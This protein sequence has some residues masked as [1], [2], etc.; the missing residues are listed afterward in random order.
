MDESFKISYCLELTFYL[1]IL[2]QTI[3]TS[4]L[5]MTKAFQYTT[6]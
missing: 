5:N 3:L 6:K 2:I 4:V 1:R